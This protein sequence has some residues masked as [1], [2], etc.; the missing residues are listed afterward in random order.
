VKTS[1]LVLTAS[2]AANVALIGAYYTGRPAASVSAPGPGAPVAASPKPA[3]S[4]DAL[5]AA[6]A[7]GD[8]AALTAAGVPA[9]TAREI[10]LGRALGRFAEKM[11]A[12]QP[13]GDAKWWRNRN[14]FAN[15]NREQSLLA[16]REL[17][18]AMI[19]AFGEDLIAGGAPGQLAFLSPQ[20]RE[21]L[22]NIMQDYE[23]MMAKYGAQGGVQ[24]A[25]DREKLKL[26]TA[27]RDRDLAA[28]LTPDELLAYQMR[29]SA[30]GSSLRSRYGDAIA[31]EEDFKKLFLL[32][33]A[34]DEKY[35][36]EGLGGRVTPEVMRQRMEANQQLQADMRAAVGEQAFQALQRASDNDLRTLDSLAAR[37]S[38][39]PDTT[40]KV[41][42]TRDSYSAESKRIMA[43]TAMPFP[44]RREQIQALAARAKSELMGTL[45]AEAA[46]AYAQRS[47]WVNMLQGGM[48]FSTNPKDAPGGGLALGGGFGPSVFP[49]MPAGMGGANI[50]QAVSFS[51]SNSGPAPVGMIINT[52]DGAGPAA[53]EHQVISIIST[54]SG[55]STSTTVQATNPGGA[56]VVAPSTPTPAA[57]PKP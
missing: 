55:P 1:T 2:L 53:G 36:M 5:R 46:E 4:P 17:S 19:A 32:Q 35:S 7:S 39:P 23:E 43:D 30:T 10:A 29:T 37:L 9:D 50:R 20:K 52:G 56:A 48:G 57:P 54:S 21:A 8:A 6:L 22:R 28:L 26:L 49:V 38:L 11:R 25:S 24:L 16:R 45:G 12:A 47:G 34:F 33:R 40:D 14:P 41:I 18:D 3:S 44:Q 51:T 13:A 42:A 27:E 31:S 15:P